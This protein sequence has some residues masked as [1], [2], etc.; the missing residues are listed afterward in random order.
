MIAA[1]KMCCCDVWFVEGNPQGI[2][3]QFLGALI[4]CKSVL[5]AP[6]QKIPPTSHYNILVLRYGL[7]SSFNVQ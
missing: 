6:S 4:G 7:G 5:T 2:G 3:M 1:Y